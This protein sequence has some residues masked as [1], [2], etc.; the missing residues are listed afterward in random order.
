M[1]LVPFSSALSHL[2]LHWSP[3]V[4]P[5]PL[6]FLLI[7]ASYSIPCVCVCVF[8]V[9]RQA[10]FFCTFARLFI[11]FLFSVHIRNASCT[12]HL[13]W[14]CFSN[15]MLFILHSMCVYVY[16][17]WLYKH[18][19]SPLSSPLYLSLSLCSCKFHLCSSLDSHR[20]IPGHL[21]CLPSDFSSSTLAKV[22]KLDSIGFIL[23]WWR[24]MYSV[25]KHTNK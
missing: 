7:F 18:F 13:I 11:C 14:A 22:Y 6:E 21:A 23:H 24:I 9:C 4:S 2:L 10:F 15:I 1:S 17:L 16:A 12:F 8:F 5:L 3:P 20:P 19:P 25:H